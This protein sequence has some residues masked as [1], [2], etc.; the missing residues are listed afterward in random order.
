M[1]TLSR[2]SMI[3]AIAAGAVAG[4]RKARAQDKR[5]IRIG[6][7]N[8]PGGPYADIGGIGSVIASR[9]AAEEVGNTLLG[10]PIEVI[11]GD[12]QNKPDVATAIA[13][14]WIDTQ[15]VEVIVDG[16]ASNS[17]LAI[18]Q[19]CRE[20]ARIF[21]MSGPA[22]SDL[23]GKF[24]SPFG[25]HFTYDT[26]ALS[27]GTARALVKQGGDTWFFITADY[28][29]G[30]ALER[31]ATGFVQA[32]GGKVLGSARAPLGSTD[33]SS[34]LVQARASGA[35][36]VGLA[37]AGTDMQNS[38]K[39][40]AEFG[41]VKGGQRLAAL[42][43]FISDVG[44]LG[45]PTAQGLVCTTSF[46]WDLTDAT[47]AWTKRFMAQRSRVPTMVQAGSYS[48]VRHWLAAVRAAGT[49]DAVAVAERMR[50]TPINDMYNRD[51]TIRADG[52]VLHT[53]YLMQVKPPAESKYPN[54][55]YTVLATT[56]GAEAFRPLKEGGCPLVH[57]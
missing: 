11:E 24:C 29:F 51:V 27:N 10:R 49:L 53:M 9:L 55:D 32:A 52:R 38:V 3:G 23:T 25:F 50:A 56:P 31:D 35:K 47:R 54:D 30:Y 45:L 7:L 2:R 18:Q 1:N 21:V 41:V 44:A 8:D 22:S 15:G 17:S 5:P 37:N 40:A 14:D 39:Q 48:G 46:Y 36:V 20:K 19:V 33:Y 4:V 34:Y 43:M 13:R 12:N 42:L 6:V 28:A 57:A 26:Y 16:S